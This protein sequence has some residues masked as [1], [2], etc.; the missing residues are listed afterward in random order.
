MQSSFGAPGPERR[1]PAVYRC[2]SGRCPSPLGYPAA[3][4]CCWLL[5]VSSRSQVTACN[6]FGKT[7]ATVAVHAKNRAQQGAPK[8]GTPKDQT[9]T[10]KKTQKQGHPNKTQKQ[11]PRNRDTHFW[12]IRELCGSVSRQKGGD[13][14]GPDKAKRERQNGP[15]NLQEEARI[16]RRGSPIDYVFSPAG[17]PEVHPPFQADSQLF[18]AL[19]CFLPRLKRGPGTAFLTHPKSGTRDGIR[20]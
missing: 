11:E 7:S 14:K 4:G 6:R 12:S 1:G 5:S 18:S 17:K 20:D 16:S 19:P 2:W 9:K 13:R 8:T 3:V 10:G 15:P